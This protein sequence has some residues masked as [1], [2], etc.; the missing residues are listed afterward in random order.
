MQLGL[1]KIYSSDASVYNMFILFYVIHKE[2]CD[3]HD[4][5]LW[6]V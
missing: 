1:D 3:L 4:H 2:L 5:I 6:P